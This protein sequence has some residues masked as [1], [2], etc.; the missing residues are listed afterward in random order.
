MRKK[1][2]LIFV[3]AKNEHLLEITATVKSTQTR[4]IELMQLSLMDPT[5]TSK[6][7]FLIRIVKKSFNKFF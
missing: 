6:Q 3:R 7:L 1:G 4:D 2:F 5:D